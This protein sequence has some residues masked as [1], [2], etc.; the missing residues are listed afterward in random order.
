MIDKWV[1]TILFSLLILTSCSYELEQVEKPINLIPKDS[2]TVIL[3]DI[4]ILE[5]YVKT[6]EGQVHNFYKTMP[7]SADSIFKIHGIDS[8]RYISSFDYYSKKQDALIEV[9]K[10]IQDEIILESAD[11][12]KK[13]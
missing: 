4:M 2:F 1:H 8:S 10:D 5:S 7:R 6:Q 3:K 9:Y 12:Q 11:L 13:E